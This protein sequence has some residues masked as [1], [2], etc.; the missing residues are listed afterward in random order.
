MSKA[1]VEV[2]FNIDEQAY[3]D[4]YGEEP[5]GETAGEALD[6]I[7]MWMRRY[8]QGDE[9]VMRF[10][11]ARASVGRPVPVSEDGEELPGEESSADDEAGTVESH[12][13]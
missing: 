12:R 1:K 7:N 2:W 10:A 11:W 4:Y 9:R 3:A 5:N 8:L 6:E 13:V